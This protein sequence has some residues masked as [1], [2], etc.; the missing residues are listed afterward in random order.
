MAAGS[1]HNFVVHGPARSLGRIPATGKVGRSRCA[2]CLACRRAAEAEPYP[3]WLA[4]RPSPPSHTR[5]NR[6]RGALPHMGCVADD[7]LLDLL[8][9]EPRR[10]AV[11]E[12]RQGE[13]LAVVIVAS[14]L[15][16]STLGFPSC[17]AWTSFKTM[18]AA[19][20]AFGRRGAAGGPHR[21]CWRFMEKPPPRPPALPSP[22]PRRCIAS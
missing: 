13:D 3:V 10:D 15:N 18:A 9:R 12:Y 1:V 17:L 16:V 22:G 8:L 6:R 11:R 21:A 5:S 19:S 7:V 4:V 14:D 2:T 20:I